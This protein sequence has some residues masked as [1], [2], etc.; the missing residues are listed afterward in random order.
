[1]TFVSPTVQNGYI[2]LPLTFDPNQL[3]QNAFASVAAQIPGWVPHEGQLDVAI[4]EEAAAMMSSAAITASQIP[5][6]IFEY[7]GQ[8]VGIVPE[9]GA[10][11]TV[12][13]IFT[14]TDSLGYTINAGTIVA[15]PLTGNTSVLFTVETTVVIPPGS[16]TGTCVLICETPGTFPNGLPALECQMVSTFAQVD[17]IATTQAV[18]SGADPETSTAYINRLSFELQLLSPRPILINDF[19]GLATNV[20]GVFRALAIDNLNPGRRITDG[21]LNSTTT[22]VS[23]TAAFVSPDDV[24][25]SVTGTGIPSSTVISSVT[26]ATTIVI[27]HAATVTGTGKTLTFGDLTGQERWAT[28]CGVDS[29]GDTLSGALDLALGAYL[30]SQREVNFKVAIIDPTYTSIDITVSCDAIHGLVSSTVQAAIIANLTSFLNT[31]TW[32]G[33]NTIP[34]TWAPSSNTVRFLDI[35][36]VVRTTSGVLYIP[37]G[38]LTFGITGGGLASTDVVLPGNAPL[39][40]VGTLTVSVTAT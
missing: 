14:M 1:M 21:V 8:L 15:Y 32:G 7:F 16:T 37:S 2:G 13:A 11:A 3:L 12:N 34:P 38:A 6:T 4:L 17:T 40:T 31:A 36:N 9:T 39:T 22:V 29:N 27:S 24:G 19:A 33:G 20:T 35:A 30:Q 5:I 18:T 10:Q 23:A 25:R 26:N 28:V